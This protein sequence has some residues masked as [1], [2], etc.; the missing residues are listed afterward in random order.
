MKCYYPQRVWRARG[1]GITFRKSDGWAD[2]ELRIRC[3]ICIGCKVN[4]SQI[5]AVRC[6]HEAQLHDRNSFV[7]LTYKPELLPSDGSLNHAHW[8]KFAKALRNRVGSFRFFMCGEYGDTNRRPHY[9]ALIFGLDFSGDRQF[10]IERRGHRTYTSKLLSEI[11]GNG[12]VEIGDLTFDS[13]AYVARY[14]TKKLSTP[15]DA[16]SQE[17]VEKHYGR[18][19][20]YGEWYM[21]R[22]EYVQMSRRPGIGSKWIE[23]YKTDVYPDDQV[24]INGKKFPSP[25]YYDKSLDEEE[26]KTIMAKRSEAIAKTTRTTD[27][28]LA[29]E[30][31]CAKIKMNICTRKI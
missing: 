14:V 28:R 5:W 24:T 11:W 21:V 19:N 16:D 18:V 25:R 4:K 23:Q 30:E 13:A 17:A 7:T 3:G 27:D 29:V 1:G 31:K 22:P 8:Q 20:E 12:F 2:R 9:H 26:L 10:H 6:V 15:H